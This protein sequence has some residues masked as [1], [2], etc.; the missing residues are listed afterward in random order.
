MDDL[1]IFYSFFEPA[2][3]EGSFL[4]VPV[5]DWPKTRSYK[6]AA[7]FVKNLPCV[8]DISEQAVALIQDFNCATKKEEQKQY[9]LVIV[10]MHRKNFE[11]FNHQNLLEM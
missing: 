9:L 11:K 5:K 3:I 7:I 1:C 2:K 6:K 10:Q 8:N 4:S